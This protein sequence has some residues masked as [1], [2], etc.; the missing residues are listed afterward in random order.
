MG[1]LK[2]FMELGKTFTDPV[3]GEIIDK[4]ISNLPHFGDAYAIDDMV[5][6]RRLLEETVES[7]EELTPLLNEPNLRELLYERLDVLKNVVNC[8]EQDKC[9]VFALFLYLFDC[10]NPLK[11][12]FSTLSN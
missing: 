6:I 1:L 12:F 5:T 3:G 8:F 10:I 4:M 9:G 7:V 2:P 11:T